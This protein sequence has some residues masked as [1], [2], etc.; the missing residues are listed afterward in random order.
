MRKII[1]R[2]L[3]IVFFLDS[4]G[5]ANMGDGENKV[6]YWVLLCEV[7][8]A[9][10]KAVNDRDGD[11]GHEAEAPQEE[12]EEGYRPCSARSVRGRDC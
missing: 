5:W 9:L 3:F 8:E 7:R 10:P 11:E 6:E 1:R 2:T 4:R 12:V